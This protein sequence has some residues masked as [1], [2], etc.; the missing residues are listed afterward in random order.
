MLARQHTWYERCGDDDVHLS[1]LFC[2]EF[3]QP[4]LTLSSAAAAADLEHFCKRTAMVHGV[5]RRQELGS[6]PT[7]HLSLDKCWTHL[8]GICARARA[9]LSC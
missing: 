4:G 8:L 3:L 9:F 1:G 7:Y 2:E 6:T 5:E